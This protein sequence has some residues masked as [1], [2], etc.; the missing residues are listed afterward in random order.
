MTHGEPM[1]V[2]S[3]LFYAFERWGVRVQALTD[4]SLTIPAGAWVNVVGPNGSGKSTFL[5]LVAGRLEMQ[6]GLLTV[7]GRPVVGPRGGTGASFLVHQ[8]P[9]QG[10]APALT[11]FE[12]LAIADPNSRRWLRG[13]AK[14]GYEPLLEMV[15]LAH[16]MEQPV[17]SLSG[18]QRQL[19][20][21]AIAQLRPSPVLLLDEPLRDSRS[22]RS[23]T[24]AARL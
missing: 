7:A 18:G 21:L 16:L 5:N 10:T 15:G 20:A 2:A 23:F 13:A 9:M 19:L 12:N 8:D 3:G 22:S 11:V 6:R 1:I 17:G 24:G 14:H 4:V